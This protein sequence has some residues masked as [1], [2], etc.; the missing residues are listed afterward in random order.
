VAGRPVELDCGEAVTGAEG[1]VSST[2]A[3]GVAGGGE[4]GMMVIEVVEGDDTSS[5]SAGSDTLVEKDADL[6]PNVGGAAT[7]LRDVLGRTGSGTFFGKL[8]RNSEGPL[9]IRKIIG[10]STGWEGVGVDA[11]ES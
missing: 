11:G 1:V 8:D 2:D 7:D 9:V 6:E 4:G 3:L 10:R 5:L